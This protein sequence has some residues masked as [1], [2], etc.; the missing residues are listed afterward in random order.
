M[1]TVLM[2]NHLQIDIFHSGIWDL[3]VAFETSSPM[4]SYPPDSF[5]THP[6]CFLSYFVILFF[7]FLLC[8]AL[9]CFALL[10]F[11][12]FCFGLLR[13]ASDYFALNCISLA[14]FERW[15]PIRYV[16]IYGSFL[17]I[18]WKWFINSSASDL[19]DLLLKIRLVVVI[20]EW[21]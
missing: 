8:F 21:Y 4:D 3:L 11:A 14:E 12:S 7:I 19:P 9:F 16:V 10:C 13:V 5:Q 1:V 6:S 2:C 15:W 18:G 20:P 17:P